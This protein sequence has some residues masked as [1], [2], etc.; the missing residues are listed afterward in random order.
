MA[1]LKFQAPSRSAG[2]LAKNARILA[3]NGGYTLS[4]APPFSRDKPPHA[5]LFSWA[6]HLF[7]YPP[8]LKP[9][10]PKRAVE[11]QI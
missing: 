2:L 9:L 4:A 1:V 6:S 5:A 3:G 11:T 10:Q 8:T 7:L